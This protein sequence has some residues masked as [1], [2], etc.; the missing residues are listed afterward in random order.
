MLT[1]LS[2]ALT[3]AVAAVSIAHAEEAIITGVVASKCVIH[4]DTMGIYGNPSQNILSTDVVDGGTAP[5]I[6]YDVVSGN[7]YKAV[8]TT[9][10]NFSSSPALNDT[11]NWTGS[12][13]VSSVTN[14]LMSAYNTNKRQYNNATE[15]NLTVPGTVWFKANSKVDYGY[16]KSLPGGTYKSIVNAECIAL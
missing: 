11:L 1:K 15:F 9:P 8:I 5:V 7:S 10:I 3:M 12:A 16:N 6:R 4:V 14:P 2:V 13:E